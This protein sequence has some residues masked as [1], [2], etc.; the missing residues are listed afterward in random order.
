[1][2][3]TVDWAVDW[4]VPILGARFDRKILTITKEYGYNGGDRIIE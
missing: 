3:W 2:D 4:T 1:M